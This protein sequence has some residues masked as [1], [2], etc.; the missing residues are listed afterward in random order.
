MHESKQ[1]LVG[2]SVC[3]HRI[4]GCIF[5]VS[6]TGAPEGAWAQPWQGSGDQRP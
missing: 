6:G 3:G 2:I 5:Q 4:I 1:C